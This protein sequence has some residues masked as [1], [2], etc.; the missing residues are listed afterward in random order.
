VTVAGDE[1][2]LIGIKPKD[3]EPGILFEVSDGV[4]LPLKSR[5]LISQGAWKF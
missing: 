4:S 2:L 1:I 3:T 5:F